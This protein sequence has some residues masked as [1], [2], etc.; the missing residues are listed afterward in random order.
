MFQ[1]RSMCFNLLGQY[2]VTVRLICIWFE[3]HELQCNNFYNLRK[4]MYYYCNVYVFSKTL[5]NLYP[6]LHGSLVRYQDMNPKENKRS[7][8]QGSQGKH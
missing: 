8:V 7:V 3:V 6:S 4:E 5:W 2:D 1:P